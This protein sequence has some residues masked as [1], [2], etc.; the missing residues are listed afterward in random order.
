MPLAL[1]FP[2]DEREWLPKLIGV[3]FEPHLHVNS[4]GPDVDVMLARE[5]ILAPLFVFVAPLLLESADDVGTQPSRPL[6]NERLQGFS[7]VTG[8]DAF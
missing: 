2:F 8:G 6:A 1:L 4:V 7:E 5:I 3:V